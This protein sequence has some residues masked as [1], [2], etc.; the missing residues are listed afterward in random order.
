MYVYP[1]TE[2]GLSA[3]LTLGATKFFRDDDLH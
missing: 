1:L 3:S 2:S